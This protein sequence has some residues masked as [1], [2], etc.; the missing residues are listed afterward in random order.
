[1]LCAC[2][3]VCQPKPCW[4]RGRASEAD[5][6]IW[7]D[8]LS[9]LDLSSRGASACFHTMLNQL[10]PSPDQD[11]LLTKFVH[12]LAR[13]G[14]WLP[15]LMASLEEIMQD[16]MHPAERFRHMD[17]TWAAALCFFTGSSFSRDT[18]QAMHARIGL[19]AKP[20]PELI[21]HRQLLPA[22][23]VAMCIAQV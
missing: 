11:V 12:T 6:A 3:A 16:A 22:V 23:A 2:N 7:P 5:P 8:I 10:L 4:C 21:R 19:P 20:L 17:A 15:V 14:K 9:Q 18:Q 13:L 1:M